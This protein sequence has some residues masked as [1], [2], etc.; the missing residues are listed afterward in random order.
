MAGRTAFHFKMSEILASGNIEIGFNFGQHVFDS[1]VYK[2]RIWHL[3]NTVTLMY[4]AKDVDLRSNAFD[5]I[6][7]FTTPLMERFSWSA[8]KNSVRCPMRD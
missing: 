6:Q 5:R 7:K 1:G 8:V 2:Q 3:I 4:M